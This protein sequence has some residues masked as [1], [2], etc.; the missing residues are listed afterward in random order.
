MIEPIFLPTFRRAW[1]ISWRH[2]GFWA[3]GLLSA[4][5]A[6]SFG[7]ENFISRIFTAAAAA[8]TV[9]WW[10]L[11]SWNFNTSPT[12]QN[13][14]G[15]VWLGGI[16][17][18]IFALVIFV[19][20]TAK[21]AMLAGAAACQKSEK[22]PA[23]HEIWHHGAACFWKMLVIELARKILLIGL[24]IAFGLLWTKLNFGG[25]WGDILG[26][27]LLALAVFLTLVV[28]SAAAYAAAYAVI[29]NRPLWE[30]IKNGW[31]LLEHH[32]LVSLEIGLALLV[33]EFAFVILVLG[34][35]SFSFIPSLFVW[36]A[37]GFLGN[38]N[39]ALAGLFFGFLL[40]LL[41]IALAGGLYSSFQT[42]VWACLFLK[43]RRGGIYSRFFHWFSHLFSR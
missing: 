39:L 23:L 29:E 11:I 19:S 34:L 10:P 8:K 4:I 9:V 7:W 14:L 18:A 2:K 22:A 12:G 28:A 38:P 37:A 6:G 16:C 41:I 15:L 30:S 20:L 32:L 31:R 13:L 17:L 42:C 36:L 35:L 26:A 1:E 40:F 24:L 25:T 3:L 5:F 27:A 33:L 43:M 21:A